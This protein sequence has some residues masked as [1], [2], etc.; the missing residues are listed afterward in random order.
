MYSSS[1]SGVPGSLLSRIRVRPL[2]GLI[3]YRRELGLHLLV[4]RRDF[5]KWFKHQ[6][7]AQ[8]VLQELQRLNRLK[9]DARDPNLFTRQVQLWPGG[10]KNRYYV[11]VIDK[12]ELVQR[13]LTTGA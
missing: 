1:N 6:Q 4:R 2:R 12:A 7:Q 5:P 10:P 11:I 8:L 13:R 9:P 3:R